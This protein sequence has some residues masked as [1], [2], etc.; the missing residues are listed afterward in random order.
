[1]ARGPEPPVPLAAACLCASA[2][3]SAGPERDPRCRDEGKAQASRRQP[4]PRLPPSGVRGPSLFF[5]SAV[6]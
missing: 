1:M 3:V 4:R 5:Y 6:F 2:W